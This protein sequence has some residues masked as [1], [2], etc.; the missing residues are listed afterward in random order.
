M[1]KTIMKFIELLFENLLWKSRWLIIVAVLSSLLLSVFVFYIATADIFSLIISHLMGPS[2]LPPDIKAQLKN[3]LIVRIIKVIDIYLLGI[4]MFVFALGLYE[5]FIS[6]IDPAMKSEVGDTVLLIKNFNDLKTKLG[7]V[8]LLILIVS[9]AQH[10]V[11][12]VYPD[13]LSLLYLG[14]GIL[15]VSGAMFLGFYQ[16]KNH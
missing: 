2:N 3:E 14:A 12:I 6:K 5:L 10:A 16:N 4:F 7:N 8:I 13:S 9:F 11:E 1:T 15:L